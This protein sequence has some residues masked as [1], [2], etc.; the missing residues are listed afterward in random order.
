MNGP[1]ANQTAGSASPNPGAVPASPANPLAPP[2]TTPQKKWWEPIWRL[3]LLVVL[4]IV[5]VALIARWAVHRATSSMTDDA[6]IEAHIVNIAPEEVSG[7]LV[8]YLVDENDRVESGQVLAEIDPV[9]YR[10][11]VELAKSKLGAAEA[12]LRRQQA[13]LD[14]LKLEVPMEIEIARRTYAAALA[15]QAKAKESLK[16][17]IDNV[18]KGV[19]EAQAGLAA[20]N[21]DLILAQEEYARFS[22]LY[23]QDAVPL[24]R[25]QEVTRSRDAADA[26]RRL[27]VAKLAKAE[28]ERTQIEVAKRTLEA[29]EKSAQKAAGGVD[30]AETGNAQIRETELLT[31]LKKQN[32]SEARR[33][34][35]SAEDQLKYTQIL[36]PFPGIIVKCYRHLGDFA[37]AGVPILSMYNPDL[38]YVTANLEET[39]LHGVAPGNDVELQV[40][41][42]AEPFRGRVVWLDKSTGAQ[43]A[44]LPRNVV[45]GEFTKVVQRVPVRI[46]IE[47]D[48][49][50]PQLRAGLSVRATIA[51]GPGDREWA[52]RAARE[53][54][55]IET[56]FNRVPQ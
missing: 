45:S 5:V 47:K 13:G 35:I 9:S 19:D 12:E 30:L 4:G 54:A 28:A 43:F 53:Q 3:A 39:R 34:L 55:A 33:A 17:T 24:R 29:A 32:V 44:L 50:W 6:F 40:D 8:R 49:R 41:A 2:A 25:S 31:A 52:D 27:A 46:L 7:R 16:L 20:A 18:E 11:Q 37:S 42:F 36:A 51:H 56:R 22:T 26:Q 1:P 23:K 15:D 21:A 14:R 48:D 10:D 38:M